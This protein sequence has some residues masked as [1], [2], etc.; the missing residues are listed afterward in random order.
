MLVTPAPGGPA[1]SNEN[2]AITDSFDGTSFSAG[3]LDAEAMWL[4]Y[5][6]D[7]DGALSWE[8]V[9]S[10]EGR[11]IIVAV[12]TATVVILRR[13]RGRACFLSCVPWG[14]ST[15]RAVCMFF[16][17]R[18]WDWKELLRVLT[19][20]NQTLAPGQILLS[21]THG[22]A[23]DI[24]VSFTPSSDATLSLVVRKGG[25]EQTVIRYAQASGA[26][27]NDRTASGILGM[28]QQQVGFI[29]PLLQWVQ[30]A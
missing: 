7:V 8:N 10:S 13:I 26:L 6:R 12:M 28:I 5:G 11:R 19:V 27:S 17:C 15:S 23:L 1:G 18:L 30:T 2:L 3:Q 14:S 22:R 24:R 16:S 29:R 20:V 4:D 25:D 9:H 21:D